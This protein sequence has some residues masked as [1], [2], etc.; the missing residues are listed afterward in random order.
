MG[1][2]LSAEAIAGQPAEGCRRRRRASIL[3]AVLRLRDRPPLGWARGWRRRVLRAARHRRRGRDRLRARAERARF[4]PRR[5]RRSRSWQAGRLRSPEFARS[6]PASSRRT[7]RHCGCSTG[8]VSSRTAKQVPTFD[9]CC[10][11]NDRRRKTVARLGGWTAETAKEAFSTPVMWGTVR[12]VASSPCRRRRLNRSPQD[13]GP[14]RVAVRRRHRARQSALCV[15][16]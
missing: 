6:V 12:V 9:S 3:R 7:L 5:G 16:E 4:R 13:A 15:V 10:L 1:P 14:E 8:S 11:V 2:R